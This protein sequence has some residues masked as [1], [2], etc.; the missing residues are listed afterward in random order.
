MSEAILGDKRS[1]RH[2]LFQPAS[3]TLNYETKVGSGLKA[4]VFEAGANLAQINSAPKTQEGPTTFN[5]FHKNAYGRP[6]SLPFRS[7]LRGP[8]MPKAF[9][10][11]TVR[12]RL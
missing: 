6:T 1:N 11:A 9:D 3:N 12:S 8:D 2:A 7:S 5:S 10:S 4:T